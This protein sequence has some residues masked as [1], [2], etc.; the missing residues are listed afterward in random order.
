MILISWFTDAEYTFP[1]D[2]AS[3]KKAEK[4]LRETDADR[5]SS[6]RALREWALQRKDWLHTPLGKTGSEV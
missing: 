2:D 1:L 4:E 3:R 5:L 6:V